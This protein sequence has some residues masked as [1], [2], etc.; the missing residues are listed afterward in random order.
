MADGTLDRSRSSFLGGGRSLTVLVYATRLGRILECDIR[1]WSCA[2]GD[3]GDSKT[4]TPNKDNK[5]TQ[6]E[7]HPV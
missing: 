4:S 2:P 7:S 1:D 3:P 5:Q 6:I